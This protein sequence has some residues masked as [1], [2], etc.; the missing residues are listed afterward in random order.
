MSA[1]FARPMP[2]QATKSKLPNATEIEYQAVLVGLL[3]NQSVDDIQTH[4]AIPN[5][6]ID[7]L[8]SEEIIECKR[9]LT[10]DALLQA[11]GQL[12]LYAV[13]YPERKLAIAGPIPHAKYYPESREHA[14]AVIERIQAIG[15]GIRIL[16]RMEPNSLLGDFLTGKQL[17]LTSAETIEVEDIAQGCDQSLESLIDRLE[18]LTWHDGLLEFKMQ[19][20]SGHFPEWMSRLEQLSSQIN[21][22]LEKSGILLGPSLEAHQ[23]WHSKN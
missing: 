22:R 11:L 3:K 9:M 19:A 23:N 14:K 10:R 8:T 12:Q 13:A 4:V 2:K 15:V 7:V 17:I 18:K 6:E 21:A 5:G 16:P 20:S 1:F